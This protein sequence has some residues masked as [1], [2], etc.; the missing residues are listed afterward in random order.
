MLQSKPILHGMMYGNARE[1]PGWARENPE[2][3]TLRVHHTRRQTTGLMLRIVTTNNSAILRH[4]G[5]PAF[6]RFGVQPHV[7]RDAEQ[8][9]A[10]VRSER[11]RVALIDVELAGNSGY[12]LSRRIKTD[13]TL[14]DTRVVLL[15]EGAITGD[16]LARLAHSQCDEVLVTPASGVALFHKIAQLLGL[17]SR[18]RRRM[19]V[20]LQAGVSVQ[21]AVIRGRV[22]D[23]NQGGA[24][25]SLQK[26]IPKGT[27]VPLRIGTEDDGELAV[28]VSAEVV[29]ESEDESGQG[30]TYGVRFI[31][32]GLN[33]RTAL[34]DL[35]LW[36]VHREPDESQLVTFQGDFREHTD[37]SRLPARLEARVI[38]DMAHVGYLNSA[39]VR[40]WVNFVRSLDHLPSYGFV[41]CSVAFV[42]QASMVPEALG[43]GQVDSFMVPYA[44]EGC[45][46]EEER[47]MQTAAFAVPGVWPPA[48]PTFRCPR[49]GDELAF[50]DVPERYFA[51]LERDPRVADVI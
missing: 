28:E 3:P 43:R 48:L 29:W 25:L 33:V 17:P 51:F 26:R 6:Q 7:A 44:C 40:N 49:C 18:S 34:E 2:R 1:K 23:L 45:D 30:W 50:D 12:D 36:E 31:D 38:F 41:R 8:T 21:A 5:T 47:L 10:L 14:G 32:P 39:G 22:V 19:S 13:A 4:L 35:S 15:L 37:F 27:A 9:L 20:S 46:L 16:V 42:T 11:P 24:R